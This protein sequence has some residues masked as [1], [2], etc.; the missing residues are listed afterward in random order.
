MIRWLWA[1]LDRPADRFDEALDFWTTVTHTRLSPRRGAHDQFVTLLPESGDAYVKAQAVG[2]RGGVHLDFGVAD[3]RAAADHAER[4]GAK[5][6][7]E[8]PGLV[9]LTSPQGLAFCMHGGGDGHEI[10]APV[11]APDGTRGK[12]DQVCID[13]GPTGFDDEARFWADLTGWRLEPATEPEFLRLTPRSPQPLRI[14][15]QRIGEDRRSSAHI[16]IACT[17]IAA[18][19]AWHESLGAQRVQQGAHWMVMADPTG[20]PYCLTGRDPHVVHGAD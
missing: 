20:A 10:P 13:I 8:E 11:A 14:L 4:L 15:L 2:D 17:D 18:Q 7:A 9:V 3:A 5:V 1:F 16:D 12:L 6:V 19:A